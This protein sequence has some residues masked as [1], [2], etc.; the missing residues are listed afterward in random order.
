MLVTRIC[1]RGSRRK[2]SSEGLPRIRG[3]VFLPLRACKKDYSVSFQFSFNSPT[4]RYRS[5]GISAS[6]TPLIRSCWILMGYFAHRIGY[7][8]A[9]DIKRV[10]ISLV[11]GNC[12]S[13]ARFV[14]LF[15]P[16]ANVNERARSFQGIVDVFPSDI[17]ERKIWNSIAR[18]CIR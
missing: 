9:E 16:P 7:S 17:D 8:R 18:P 2:R 12:L 10:S 3:W 11:L 14:I 13:I 15:Q 4:T 6:A 1:E 5:R